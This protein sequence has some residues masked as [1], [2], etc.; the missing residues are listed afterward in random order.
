MVTHRFADFLEEPSQYARA[1]DYW[2][3][4][5]ERVDSLRRIMDGWKSPWFSNRLGDG[6]LDMDG[7]PIFSAFS[8]SLRK[9]L[10]IIQYQPTS[11]GIEF[12]LWQDTFGG[13]R[14][15]PEAIWELVIACALCDEAADR[16]F[17]AISDW[18]AG[19]PIRITFTQFHQ[20]K[21][22]IT[23]GFAALPLYVGEPGPSLVTV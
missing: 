10:R 16:A 14:T 18:V 23:E 21:N 13:G 12:D 9:G 11:D 1:V 7:N 20:R 8:P 3:R 17:G 19:R 15:D 5:W 22:G 6:S 4:L 2:V